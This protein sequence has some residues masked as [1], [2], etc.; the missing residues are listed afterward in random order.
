MRCFGYLDPSVTTYI[1]Q[2]GAGIVIA[3]VAF[4][5]AHRRS[6]KK[7]KKGTE[8]ESDKITIKEKK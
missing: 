1:V 8:V 6:K 2:A 3:L 7:P 5:R 4:F